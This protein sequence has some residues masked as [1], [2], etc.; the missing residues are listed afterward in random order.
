MGIMQNLFSGATPPP[1]KPGSPAPFNQPSEQDR[2]TAFYWLKRGMSFTYASHIANQCKE[3]TTDYETW[4]RKQDD[5]YESQIDVL[6][7]LLDSVTACDKGLSA[8]KRGDRST[9]NGKS[10]EGWLAKVPLFYQLAARQPEWEGRIEFY[11]YVAANLDQGGPELAA[12]MPRYYEV[13]QSEWPGSQKTYGYKN[14][15]STPSPA[16]QLV[17]RLGNLAQ[18]PEP[19]WDISMAPGK[20]A[21]RNGIYETVNAQGYIIGGGMTYY[22]KGDT[23]D[24]YEIP[25][26][27]P[28]ASATKEIKQGFWYRLL[29]EDARYKDGSIP[30]EEKLYLFDTEAPATSPAAASY[31][32]TASDVLHA[33]TGETALRGGTWVLQN[34]LQTRIQVQKGDKLPQHLGRDASWVWSEQS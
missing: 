33:Y 8:L 16:E 24:D 20:P 29:W 18:L 15:T 31:T 5:P 17:A 10:S 12:W 2:L 32:G 21:P 34:D 22:L 23:C 26:Y 25:E 6:K 3:I 27:G 19:Q 4:L 11:D 28:D 14:R 9:F 7:Y 1:L 30:D 13:H